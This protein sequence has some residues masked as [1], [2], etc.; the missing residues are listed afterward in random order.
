MTLDSVSHI[1]AP[2]W[3]L[4]KEYELRGPVFASTHS[5]STAFEQAIHQHMTPL[6]TQNVSNWQQT[7]PRTDMWYFEYIK[8]DYATWCASFDLL[9]KNEVYENW[10]HDWLLCKYCRI[11]IYCC[12]ICHGI[13]YNLAMLNVEWWSRL[14]G[15][16]Q[17]TGE[18]WGVFC[19][20]YVS[21]V[22][23]QER[24]VYIE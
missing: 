3:Q 16:S 18:L 20:R 13:T 11:A 4:S 7:H 12:P 17:K 6:S 15:N 1:T 8:S 14:H 19:D 10:R 5:K 23:Y 9:D 2:L 24:I 21:I 22:I